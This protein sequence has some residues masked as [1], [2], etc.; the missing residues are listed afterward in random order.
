MLWQ[1]P[2][3]SNIRKEGLSAHIWN[4]IPSLQGNPG[5]RGVGWLHLQLGSR[6]R[7]TQ[8]SSFLSSFYS[9]LEPSL[10]HDAA[11]I[12]DVFSLFSWSSL[13]MPLPTRTEASLPLLLLSIKLTIKI[14]NH[15]FTIATLKRISCVFSDNWVYFSTT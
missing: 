3:Q 9:T 13:E 6:E 8:A 11:H 1:N 5:S 2:W 14:C 4:C 10:W 12:Q 7:R 15:T